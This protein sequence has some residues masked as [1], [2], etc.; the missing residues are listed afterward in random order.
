MGQEAQVLDD[1]YAARLKEVCKDFSSVV[2][3]V[4]HHDQQVLEIKSKLGGQQV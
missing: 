4:R 3:H 1:K 2:E